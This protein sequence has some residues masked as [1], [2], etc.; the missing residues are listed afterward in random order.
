MQDIFKYACCINFN[1]PVLTELK[2]ANK[3]FFKQRKVEPWTNYT[4][5][6]EFI[7]IPEI[8]LMRLRNT[9]LISVSQC[10]QLIIKLIL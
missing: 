5:F 1:D 3:R 4:C 10:S 7:K 2:E 6:N 9:F 8:C